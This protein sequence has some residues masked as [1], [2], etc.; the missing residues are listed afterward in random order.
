MLQSL[1]LGYPACYRSGTTWYAPATEEP[2]KRAV[3][4]PLFLMGKIRQENIGARAVCLG[5]GF[6]IGIGETAFLTRVFAAGP[7]TDAA[8]EPRSTGTPRHLMRQW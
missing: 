4:V 7:P 2:A 8:A 1:L 5:C 3:L 6:G